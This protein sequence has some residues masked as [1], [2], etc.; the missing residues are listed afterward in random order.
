MGRSSITSKLL[1]GFACLL[2]LV[3]LAAI[4]WGVIDRASA[5]PLYRTLY[6]EVP[7]DRERQSSPGSPE[8]SFIDSPTAECYLPDLKKNACFIQW[9]Y[10]QV[11]ATS[12]AYIISMTVSIDN[13]LRAHYSGFFQDYMYVPVDAHIPGF[14]IDCGSLGQ[15]GNADMGNTY[16]YVI[17]ARETGGLSSANYGSV[18]C[19]AFQGYDTYLPLIMRTP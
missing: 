17:R 1:G 6:S 9:E 13:H 3:I 2:G 7:P 8:I 14:K 11:S 15:G 16:S 12:P 10:L 5:A 18:T 4:W 19:P